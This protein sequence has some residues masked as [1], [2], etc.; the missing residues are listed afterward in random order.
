MG[1]LTQNVKSAAKNRDFFADNDLYKTLQ[2]KLEIYQFIAK[3][4]A[5]ETASAHRLLDIGNGGVFIFPIGHIPD[6]EAIDIFVEK[7]FKTRYPT[8]KWS[9]MSA[10]DMHFD[11]PFDTVIAINTLHH[12]IGDTVKAT[13]EN[14]DRIMEEV[15]KNLEPNGKFVL[16]ESTVPAWF[17]AP[18]KFIFALLIKLWPLKHPPTFQFYFRDILAA[19]D[20]AGLQLKEFCWIPKTSD[21]M[22]FGYRVKPWMSPIQMGK[23]V[24]IKQA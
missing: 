10:L 8:V 3:S 5:H 19:G 17:I 23:F 6:V 13:Y 24:F 21:F 4:A 15:T 18:Y 1:N 11:K 12:V 16:L 2:N 22:T 14:L 7:D 20:K 9:Q